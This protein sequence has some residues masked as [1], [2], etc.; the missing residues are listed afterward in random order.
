M[1]RKML[2]VFIL[3]WLS[4]VCWAVDTVTTTWVPGGWNIVST[5]TDPATV[6]G[7]KLTVL[8]TATYTRDGVVTTSAPES[9]IV[10]VGASTLRKDWTTTTALQTYY[11]LTPST[12][13]TGGCELLTDGK[14]HWWVIATNN[15]IAVSFTFMLKY[16]PP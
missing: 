6:A 5:I 4:S 11:K 16:A 2:L 3:V 9:I 1:L 8:A 14:L 12:T 7:T 15:G 10:T 13:A